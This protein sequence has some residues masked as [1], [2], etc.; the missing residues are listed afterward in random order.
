ML[1]ELYHRVSKDTVLLQ[2]K[3]KVV[4]WKAEDISLQ[5]KFPNTDA[6]YESIENIEAY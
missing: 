3:K 2:K 6:A 5:V 1:D 4:L